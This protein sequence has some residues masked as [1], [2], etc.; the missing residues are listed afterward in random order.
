MSTINAINADEA[1][2]LLNFASSQQRSNP[3]QSS[4]KEK[5]REI[6][7]AI[8]KLTLIEFGITRMEIALWQVEFPKKEASLK[9]RV[10][11]ASGARKQVLREFCKKL[12]ESNIYHKDDIL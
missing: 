8:P 6:T 7:V 4:P 12:Y 11:W 3:S 2:L 10:K 5:E 1:G 9:E